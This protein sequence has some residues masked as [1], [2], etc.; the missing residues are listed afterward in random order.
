MTL[1]NSGKIGI[2]SKGLTYGLVKIVKCSFSSFFFKILQNKLF[3]YL[4]E[5]K[6]PLLDYKSGI[7]RRSKYWNGFGQNFKIISQFVFL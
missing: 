4:L 2:F 6:T 7:T 3:A 5:I 1:L